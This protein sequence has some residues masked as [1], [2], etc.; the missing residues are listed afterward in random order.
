MLALKETIDQLAMAD[1]VRWYGHVL[2]RENSHVLRRVLDFEVESQRKKLRPN[3]MW[4]G[5]V[6]EESMKAGLRREGAL[7]RSKWSV[8]VIKIAVGLK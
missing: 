8:G 7:C 4:K 3:R 1:S 6:E 2:R 5:Q